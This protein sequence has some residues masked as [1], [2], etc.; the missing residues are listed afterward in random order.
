MFDEGINEIEDSAFENCIN[1]KTI[2]LSSGLKVIGRYSFAGT[3]IESVEIPEGCHTVK[4]GAFLNCRKL[5]EISFPST[6]EE[7][8]LSVLCT[9]ERKSNPV[10]VKIHSWNPMIVSDRTD[11][12][13]SSLANE[14]I[15][16]PNIKAVYVPKGCVERYKKNKALSELCTRILPLPE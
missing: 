15:I 11:A 2:S 14:K 9:T 3:Q 8:D 10:I 6:M 13:E 12:L 1:L 4:Q 16:R 5:K 7:I